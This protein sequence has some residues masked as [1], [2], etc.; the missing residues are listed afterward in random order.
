MAKSCLFESDVKLLG[1]AADGLITEVWWNAAFP[2]AS[3]IDG[4]SSAQLAVS[5]LRDHPESSGIVPP[6]VGYQYANVEILCDILTRAGSLELSAINR[7]AAETDLD[8]VVGHVQFGDDHVSVMGCVAGQWIR[9]E[10]GSFRQEI[11]GNYLLHHVPVT[12]EVRTIWELQK[13]DA[14]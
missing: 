10:D 6:T 2:G 13:E 1:D 14:P 11:V 8:T 4:T 5:Y 7:A 12:A 9:N 3:S